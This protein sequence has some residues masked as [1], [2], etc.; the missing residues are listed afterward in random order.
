M[1]AYNA[2]RTLASAAASVLN[3]TMDD[4]E[5]II[6]DDGSTD[7]TRR[8]AEAI[9]DPRV[10]L[11]SQENAGA[12]AARNAGIRQARGGWVAFLD[13]DD[14]WLP[15]KLVRQLET[16]TR[17]GHDAAQ[18]S[19]IFVDDSLQPLEARLCRPSRDPLMDFLRFRNMPA[20]METL[21]VSTSLLEAIGGFARDLVI[22]EDWDIMIRLAR[23]GGVAS[24]M[25]PLALYRVHAGNRSRD[26]SMHVE[27]GH[28]VLGRLFDDPTLPERVRRRER[29][30]Y[31]RFYTMLAGGAYTVG[32]RPGVVHWGLKAIQTDPRMLLYMGALP[33]RRIQRWR[34]RRS[35][36]ARRF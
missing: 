6:V 3:Q 16:L 34:S 11:V 19:V 5:L 23:A 13:A 4:L 12:A 24:M 7:G 36:G 8:V 25:E 29:E 31:A 21:I 35:P 1:P 17:T 22:L 9:E 26:T 14:F 30:I 18:A 28:I 27:P 15:H 20:V 2:E 33:A 32:D 10:R